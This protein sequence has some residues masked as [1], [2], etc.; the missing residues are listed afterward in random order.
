M[1]LTKYRTPFTKRIILGDVSQVANLTIPINNYDP[2][3][4]GNIASNTSSVFT[5]NFSNIGNA[6]D[7]NSAYAIELSNGRFFFLN[8]TTTKASANSTAT[9]LTVLGFPLILG[10][11]CPSSFNNGIT[12]NSLGLVT[13]ITVSGTCD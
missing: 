13:S 8:T 5:T 4:F 6:L 2:I 9:I 7:S 10:G 12:T 1:P 11:T 3:I